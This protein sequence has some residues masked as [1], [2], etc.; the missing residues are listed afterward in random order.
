MLHAFIRR[1]PEGVKLAF[2]RCIALTLARQIALITVSYFQISTHA[3]WE[4][5]TNSK[6]SEG[7][8]PP[9]AECMLCPLCT[10]PKYKI[11]YSVLCTLLH[12]LYSVPGKP[13]LIQEVSGFSLPSYSSGF[14]HTCQAFSLHVAET[15]L[16]R[17]NSLPRTGINVALSS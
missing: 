4:V 6:R 16:Y 8:P 2:Q 14:S 12:I 15:L 3:F 13:P 10:R 9:W 5:L 17:V 11:A 7:D 1:L